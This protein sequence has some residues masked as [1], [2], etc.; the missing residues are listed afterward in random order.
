MKKKTISPN[1]I[2]ALRNNK[3]ISI[4]ALAKQVGIS[5]GQLSRLENGISGLKPKWLLK[6]AGALNVS[7][8]EIINLP[9]NKKSH[10]NHDDVL[11]GE[12][13]GW[14]ME[15]SEELNVVIPRQKLSKLVS[16]IYKEYA[17][18][19]LN[20][21]DRKHLAYTA[22]RVLKVASEK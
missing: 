3:G 6:L 12:A 4:H 16:L 11:M 2:T 9:F 14:L 19:P 21:Q 10:S 8:S 17:G 7:T 18:R 22:V 5:A 15:A 13:I 1:N 20:F